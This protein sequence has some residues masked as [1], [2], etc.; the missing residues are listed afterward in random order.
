MN[1]VYKTRGDS[2]MKNCFGCR[3]GG[4]KYYREEVIARQIGKV[5]RGDVFYEKKRWFYIKSDEK[6]PSLQKMNLYKK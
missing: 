3:G 1:G 5:I 4:E 6:N 2:L